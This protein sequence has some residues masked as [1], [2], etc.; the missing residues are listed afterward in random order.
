MYLS[1]DFANGYES[2]D[3]ERRFEKDGVCRE[4]KSMPAATP[5]AE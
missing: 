4:H 1:F 3:L 2:V 5:W